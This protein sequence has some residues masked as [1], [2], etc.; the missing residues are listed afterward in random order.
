[1]LLLASHFAASVVRAVKLS[2]DWPAID[3]SLSTVS[4]I[5]IPVTRPTLD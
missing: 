1:M 2:F 5:L 4:W 3:M